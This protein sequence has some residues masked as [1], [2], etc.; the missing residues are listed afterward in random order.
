[1]AL[2]QV[3]RAV[4]ARPEIVGIPPDRPAPYQLRS[5]GRLADSDLFERS[6]G[7]MAE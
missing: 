4:A 2:R 5:I 3:W 6:I 7:F 1:M